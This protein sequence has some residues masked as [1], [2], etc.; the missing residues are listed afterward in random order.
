MLPRNDTARLSLATLASCGVSFVFSYLQ[1]RAGGR[2]NWN[3]SLAVVWDTFMVV[4]LCLTWWLI[5]RATPEQTR[6][7]ALQA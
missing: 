3:A 7:W 4:Y 1:A 6:L 5:A 2:P